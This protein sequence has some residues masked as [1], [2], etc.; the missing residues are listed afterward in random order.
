MQFVAMT[1]ALKPVG[2]PVGVSAK[3]AEFA[4]AAVFHLLSTADAEAS[5]N[6]HDLKR[7]KQLTISFVGSD[8]TQPLLRLTFMA[9]EGLSCANT[10][11]SALA[12]D[13]NLRLGSA[14]FAVG[15]VELMNSPW[16]GISTWDD[17]LAGTPDASLRLRFM[18]PTAITKCSADG[19]RFMSLYPEPRDVF[20]GLIR[21]WKGL[22]GPE[23][24]ADL[25]DFVASGSCFVANHALQT[26]EF[27][28]SERVQIG[29]IGHVVYQCRH[30][31][32][33]HLAA[34]NALARLAFFSGV[35]YQTA[36]GMGAVLT[37]IGRLS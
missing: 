6:L 3:D 20:N 12:N 19:L 23:L 22:G 34:L 7:N 4:H 1:V 30:A 37:E 14:V 13:S 36:R 24:P 15:E 26:I 31:T 33:T 25:S 18:T 2:R 21:R 11:I 17:L 16:V 5:R 27:R 28:T 10:L 29:F 32:Q 35:G 8:Q 9:K